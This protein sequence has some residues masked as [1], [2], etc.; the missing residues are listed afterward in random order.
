MRTVPTTELPGLDK[1]V[2]ETYSAQDDEFV[3]YMDQLCR[4]Y[5]RTDDP[6]C[7]PD[8]E[9]EFTNLPA[10]WKVALLRYRGVSVPDVIDNSRQSSVQLG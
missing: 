7:L 9:I 4:K 1:S 2:N 5:Q 3:R 10:N 6:N 8:R